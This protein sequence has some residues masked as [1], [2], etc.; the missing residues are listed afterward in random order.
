MVIQM[1]LMKVIGNLKTI[2]I[3]NALLSSQPRSAHM[4]SL[5][6]DRPRSLLG[7]HP[8]RSLA[9][10]CTSACEW[11]DLLLRI[12]DSPTFNVQSAKFNARQS[13]HLLWILR[14][15]AVELRPISKT[16]VGRSA[17]NDHDGSPLSCDFASWFNPFC[18]DDSE[19][20]P[21]RIE[22]LSLLLLLT[23]LLAIPIVCMSWRLWSG[24]LQHVQS[25]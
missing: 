3:P 22:Y 18:A 16:L 13:P 12:S 9:E 1:K 17:S 6:S 19:L 15:P 25:M 4:T 11:T 24:H 7:L 23:I 20:M 8:S 2:S 21:S 10:H 5:P 14:V